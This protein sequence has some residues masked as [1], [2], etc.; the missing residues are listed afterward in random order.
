MGHWLGGGEL[1]VACV[2]RRSQEQLKEPPASETSLTA[3]G[4]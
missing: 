2:Y 4:D 1:V 3:R